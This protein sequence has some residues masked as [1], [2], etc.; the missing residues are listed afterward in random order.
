MEYNTDIHLIGNAHI[1]LLWLWKWE[2][3]LQEIRSTFASA[4]D[5]IREHG[6]FIF[7]SACAYYYSLVER[8]DPVLFEGIREAVK[9]GR[10]C[11]AGGWWLQPD[12]NAPAGEAFARQG[13][14]G[15]GYFMEKF[16]KRARFGYNV[17]SFGHH[18]NLPQFLKKSGL[19]GYVFMRPGAQEKTL[20]S[21]LFLWKGIDGSGVLAF[22]LIPGY[23][24]SNDWGEGLE[25]KILRI[26]EVSKS[27]GI[28]LMCFYGVG[29]H[30]GGPTRE[31]LAVIDG[32]RQRKTGILYSDPEKYFDQVFGL[33]ARPVLQDELQYHAIGCYSALSRIKKANNLTEQ[34]LLSAEKTLAVIGEGDDRRKHQEALREAWKKVLVNQ[35]HDSLGGCSIP[36][37]YPKIF[38]AYGWGQETANQINALLLNRLASRIGTFKDGSTLILWNPHPWELKTAVEVLAIADS[39]RDAGDGDVPFELVPT[40]AVTTGFFSGAMRFTAVLPPLGYRSYKL[41]NLRNEFE[42]GTFLNLR[43]NRTGSNRLVSGPVELVI[44][45]ETGFITSI[46]DGERHIEY[47]DR[48]GTGPVIIDDDSDTWTHGLSSYRGTLRKMQLESFRL[49]S[50]G[51]VTTEYEILYTL[52]QSRVIMRVIVNGALRSVDLRIRVLWN[53][54]R[55]LLKLRISSA[56]K[57]D[58][59]V[60]GIPYGSI[61]RAADGTE[62]PIQRWVALSAEQRPGA[63]GNSG[64]ALGVVNDGIYSCSVES[65]VLGLTLLRSPLF[66]H[67]EP[68]HPPPDIQPRYIDQGEHEYHV[69]LHLSA[70]QTGRDEYARRALELNQPP[71]Y[72]IESAHPGPLP[73]ERSYC[74]VRPGSGGPGNI[75]VIISTIKRAEDDEG[76]IIRAVEAGGNRAAVII[77]FIWLGLK[78][79]FSFEPFEIKTIRISDGDGS[80]RETNLLEE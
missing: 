54:G 45:R 30:G 68:A 12:C 56:F 9:A 75:T 63:F 8:T 17:D 23:N 11:I 6:T 28:P 34:M 18:G 65:N 4:L 3:G 31:N 74:C 66:S 35:F 62:W 59:F 43:Y 47:L 57:N 24:N 32:L 48:D 73:P 39:I 46:Y 2:D 71:A 40:N 21:S 44:D 80:V 1:D 53:E 60:S 20:P 77:D 26:E 67:H 29:N 76:W 10:W 33:G 52:F 78:G 58:S 19:E 16:G 15:Q 70:G 27:G 64:P 61:E 22:R 72:V 55:R 51:A 5:R 7:T 41:I 25:G 49:I 36:E 69:R 42:T 79:S 14:Y 13:L 38:G 37:A 50:Q